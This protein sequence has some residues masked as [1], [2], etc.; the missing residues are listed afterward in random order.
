MRRR[1]ILK[2]AAVSAA[3]PVVLGAAATPAA[4]AT[5]LSVRG[6]DIS[7]LPKSEA[8]G[9]VYYNSAGTRV[10]PVALLATAGISH[11]RLKVWV[12]P[13]DGYNNKARILPP[14]RRL[15]AQG[16]KLII[17]FHY[18]DTWADPGT[19]TKPAAWS[20]YSVS[21]L[22][23]AVYNHTA[24]VLGALVSQGTPADLVQIG[25][26]LNGGMLWPDGNWEHLDNL[27]AFLKSGT[28][29]A[30][31]TTPG[32]RTILH[33]A[34]GGTQSLYQ[35][36]FD[37]MRSR[38]VSW[39]V[40]GLSFYPYWHG[41]LSALSA[42]LAFVTNRYATPAIV[43]ET[44]YPW[45]LA[46]KDSTGNIVN[47]A[48]QLTSGYPATPA[49]QDAWIRAI[50]DTVAAT[51]NNRGLGYVYWEGLWTAVTGNGWDPANPSSGNAWENQALFDYNS[52]ALT[53][54]YTV[55]SY[56]RG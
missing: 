44:A 27:A 5:T 12:N 1:T 14:A 2:A 52:R 11:A 47:S 13:A 29:A 16:I 38:G 33:L 24:D 19:Q 22:S 39:N 20:S 53:G 50:A 7:S 41:T 55:G 31:A 21:Q 28:N 49:G 32:V 15:S 56:R 3:T 48:S 34:N 37:N 30:R 36:F 8:Y 4:A 17:D 23:T 35:W 6:I 46:N 40:I 51:P 9:G 43:V 10:D 54:F 42:N 26:E 18:S 45:T 25:N